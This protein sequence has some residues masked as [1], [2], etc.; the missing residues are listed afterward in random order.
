M[1][2]DQHIWQH[3]HLP[4]PSSSCKMSFSC[5]Q[6]SMQMAQWRFTFYLCSLF[7]SQKLPPLQ[8]PHCL[9]HH[10]CTVL[11]EPDGLGCQ[12]LCCC[13]VATSYPA[14]LWRYG[15]KPARLLCPWNS[16]GKNTRVDCHFLLQGNLPNSEMEPTSPSLQADSLPLIHQGSPQSLNGAK[17]PLEV[18]HGEG[19]PL[20]QNC[21]RR[22]NCVLL[23]ETFL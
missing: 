1:Y 19:D 4:S 13:L 15:L 21:C 16:P 12:F 18:W 8:C 5:S 9:K 23:E 2:L 11:E 17:I 3:I 20:N 22:G 7:P 10:Q 6:Q 14:L